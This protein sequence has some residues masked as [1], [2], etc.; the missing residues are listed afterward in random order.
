MPGVKYVDMSNLS[1]EELDRGR[2]EFLEEKFGRK[3]SNG[4]C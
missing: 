3:F 1:K 4:G 2:E